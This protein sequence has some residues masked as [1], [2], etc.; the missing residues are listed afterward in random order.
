MLLS[1]GKLQNKVGGGIQVKIS[2]IICERAFLAFLLCCV[3]KTFGQ[4]NY[5]TWGK[6]KSIVINTSPT[7]YDLTSNLTN[8][9][10]LVRID[11][12]DSVF[13]QSLVSNGGD[14]RFAKGTTHLS[15]QIEEYDATAKTGAIWVLVN[16]IAAGSD[17]QSI[18][19]YWGKA[20]VSDSSNGKAVFATANGFVGVWHFAASGNFSDATTNAITLTN[21]NTTAGTA[22]L[23]GADRAFNGTNSNLASTSAVLKLKNNITQ[24]VW[25]KAPDATADQK[26]MGRDGYNGG[27]KGYLMAIAGKLDAEYDGT[28]NSGGT[29]KNNIWTHIAV[30]WTTNGNFILYVNGSQVATST[31]GATVLSD[32]FATSFYI[33][34]PGWD[35]GSLLFSGELDEARVEN[36]VRSADWLKL[37]F[38][39]QRVLPTAPPVIS[40]PVKHIFIPINSFADSIKPSITG[41]VDSM[42]ITPF[43]LPGDL[44][45]DNQTGVITGN[46]VELAGGA[47]FVIT[48]YNSKGSS[49]DTIYLTI[50]DPAGVR[51]SKKNFGGAPRLIGLSGLRQQPRILFFAP[52]TGFADYTFAIYNLR[53]SPVW[54]SHSM[55]TVPEGG[56]QSVS[57]GDWSK[58]RKIAAGMYFIEMKAVDKVS[59]K[60]LI[61]RSKSM[62]VKP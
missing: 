53:G 49:S 9:P 12:T 59:G 46:A 39:N 5:A 45:F 4:E 41:I 30:T 55:H 11:S 14:I 13:S 17:T 40:Y 1:G 10:Y 38:L 61:L 2:K 29:I 25:V 8:F 33:G 57:T 28:R 36:A 23:I 56:I 24:S 50:G 62:V 19:M 35:Q 60:A 58:G 54:S 43:P 42:S 34:C 18:T 51:A 26:V 3:W 44:M 27:E 22:P 6:S 48:V 21:N 52:S 20:G 31:T 32:T 15:Y 47:P 7:G 37:C 16:S